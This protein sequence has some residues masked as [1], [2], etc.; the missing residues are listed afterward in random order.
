MQENNLTIP[1][2]VQAFFDQR[3]VKAPYPGTE[4]LVMAAVLYREFIAQ[5]PYIIG[6]SRIDSDFPMSKLEPLVATGSYDMYLTAIGTHAFF[7]DCMYSTDALHLDLMLDP[8]Y[9]TASGYDSSAFRR[10]IAPFLSADGK[11]KQDILI[12]CRCSIESLQQ[13]LRNIMS[14]AHQHK[15][16]VLAFR[17]LMHAS[18]DVP[19]AEGRFAAFIESLTPD[20][21]PS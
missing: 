14:L 2:Q 10:Q 21:K 17:Q 5:T 6:M 11:P 3:E 15:R 12:G 18:L 19:E 7:G 20:Q 16:N 13:M 1:Q 8:A 9:V 4:N